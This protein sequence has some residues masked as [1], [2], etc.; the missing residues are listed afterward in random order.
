MK[1]IPI[2]ERQPYPHTDVLLAYRNAA[3]EMIVDAGF[4]RLNNRFVYLGM[5]QVCINNICAWMP[6]PAPPT[7]EVEG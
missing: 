4:M 7:V 3:G 1:W 5:E 6:F 2:T